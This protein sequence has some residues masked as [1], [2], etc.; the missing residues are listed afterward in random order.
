MDS[1]VSRGRQCSGHSREHDEGIFAKRG[2]GF[3]GH[4]ASAQHDPLTP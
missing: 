4:E 2:N 3:K 1:G